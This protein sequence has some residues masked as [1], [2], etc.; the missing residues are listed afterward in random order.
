MI[1]NLPPRWHYEGKHGVCCDGSCDGGH[2]DNDMKGPN[3]F[4]NWVVKEYIM[5][6][7]YPGNTSDEQ[8]FKI[9]QSL[10]DSGLTLFVCLQLESELKHFRPYQEDLKQIA[11]KKNIELEFLH[12][13]IED[14]GVAENLD[15]LSDFIDLLIEKLKSH[16]IYLHCWAG[17]GR[18]GIIA[19]CLLGRL[20]QVSGLEACRRIQACYEQRVVGFG[21]SPE[22][23]PQKMQ[24]IKYLKNLQSKETNS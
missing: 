20:Y 14:G 16:R 6:G 5:T 13:P 21:E 22:Y 2:V 8:H 4:S 19:A 11:A 9:L 15:E 23:H 18:T 10:V 3:D 7:E 17:R 12:F 1:V 24:V